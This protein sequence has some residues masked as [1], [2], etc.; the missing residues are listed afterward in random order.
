[1]V[2]LEPGA[3]T[4]DGDSAIYFK[5]FKIIIINMAIGWRENDSESSEI[6]DIRARECRKNIT[7]S[8]T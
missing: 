7:F 1:M 8:F 3:A 2:K 5:S 4:V 6:R